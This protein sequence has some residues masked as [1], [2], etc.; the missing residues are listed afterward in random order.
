MWDNFRDPED[1]TN[2]KWV[3]SQHFYDLFSSVPEKCGDNFR[4]NQENLGQH[5]DTLW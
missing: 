5:G 3:V 1:T 2:E 4:D